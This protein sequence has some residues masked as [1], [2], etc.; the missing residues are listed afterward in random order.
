MMSLLIFVAAVYLV[1]VIGVCAAV[2][3]SLDGRRGLVLGLLLGPLGLLISVL[4]GM[5]AQLREDL[6][7]LD[8]S[9]E[10]LD[11]AM[12]SLVPWGRARPRRP[13]A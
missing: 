10:H 3:R 11:R 12:T 2:G 7:R 6:Q 9:I 1:V 4:M 13:P 5:S 8:E